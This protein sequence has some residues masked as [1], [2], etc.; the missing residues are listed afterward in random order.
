MGI[1]YL[2]VLKDRIQLVATQKSGGGKEICK[3][4]GVSEGGIE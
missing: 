1:P 3:V 2:G 4:V